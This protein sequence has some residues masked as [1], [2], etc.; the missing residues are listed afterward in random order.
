[1]SVTRRQV[2][3]NTVLTNGKIKTLAPLRSSDRR[4]ITDQIISQYEVETP[5][6]ETGEEQQETQPVAPSGPGALRNSLLPE[7]SLSAKFSTTVGQ[8]LKT[9]TGTLYV[10]THPGEEQ[11]VLWI[12]LEDKVFPT[13]SIPMISSDL[14]LGSDLYI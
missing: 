3:E 10:G 13:G 14:S 8:D 6:Q 9:V 2:G 12:R 1:M 7:G 11:R 5:I 4:R